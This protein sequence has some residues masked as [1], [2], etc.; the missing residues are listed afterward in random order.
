V[1][2]EVFQ[3]DVEIFNSTGF[4]VYLL[5]DP[6]CS[7][8]S[9]QRSLEIFAY[10]QNPERFDSKDSFSERTMPNIQLIEVQRCTV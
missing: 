6:V 9:N 4:S 10:R 5:D 1:D 7:Y 8:P 2:F 3:V